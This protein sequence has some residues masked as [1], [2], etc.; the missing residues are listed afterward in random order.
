MVKG[1]RGVLVDDLFWFQEELGIETSD[2][3]RTLFD[4]EWL[5]YRTAACVHFPYLNTL[6]VLKCLVTYD[7]PS[8]CPAEPFSVMDRIQITPPSPSPTY[9]ER[10]EAAQILTNI[11]DQGPPQHLQVP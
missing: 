2:F 5:Q 4:Q 3:M 7:V 10:Q 9:N 11:S 1:I 6:T 8:I